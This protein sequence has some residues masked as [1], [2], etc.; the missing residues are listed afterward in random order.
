MGKLVSVSMT[1]AQAEQMLWYVQRNEGVYYGNKDQFMRRERD[2]ADTI[3]KAIE[4]AW[5]APASM[6]EA[7]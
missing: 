2:L 1:K 5:P 3:F 6:E 7:K 4:K